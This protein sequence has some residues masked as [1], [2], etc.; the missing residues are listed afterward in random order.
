VLGTVGLGMKIK[1]P[2]KL[3]KGG[4]NIKNSCKIPSKNSKKY[5]CMSAKSEKKA[6]CQN[7]SENLQYLSQNALK[8][9]TMQDFEIQK[10]HSL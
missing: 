6:K 3:T 4:T 8:L 10:Q 5:L 7:A 9:L 1:C 2:Q